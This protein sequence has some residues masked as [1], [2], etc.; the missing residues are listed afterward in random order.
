MITKVDGCSQVA[1]GLSQRPDHDANATEKQLAVGR[2]ED[3]RFRDRR[4][5]KDAIFGSASVMRW[6]DDGFAVK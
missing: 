4:I 5:P 2:L 6:T 1:P 3:V